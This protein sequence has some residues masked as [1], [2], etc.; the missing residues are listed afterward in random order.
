MSHK[1]SELIVP[2]AEIFNKNTHLRGTWEFPQ[3]Q[4][5]TLVYFALYSLC[6]D[7][8]HNFLTADFCIFQVL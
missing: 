3:A 4:F 1:H 6:R 2:G 5:L 7:D 8:S